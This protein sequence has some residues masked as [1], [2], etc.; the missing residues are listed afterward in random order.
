MA[1]RVLVLF[2][3]SES[4]ET[5][6]WAGLLI[7]R[8]QES[9]TQ[10]DC[11]APGEVECGNGVRRF[12]TAVLGRARRGWGYWLQLSIV[13]PFHSLILH[14]S[15]GYRSVLTFN[16]HLS[17]LT[18]LLMPFRQTSRVLYLQKAPWALLRRARRSLLVRNFLYFRDC[19]GVMASSQVVVP[20]HYVVEKILEEISFLNKRIV[21]QPFSVEDALDN[22]AAREAAVGQE[23]S[24]KHRKERQA[25]LEAYDLPERAL[26]L[27]TADDLIEREPVEILVRAINAAEEERMCLFVL[28]EGPA[29]LQLLAI[30][31]GLGLFHR[32]IFVANP[33]QFEEVIVG[34]DLYVIGSEHHG[35]TR[36]LLQAFASGVPVLAADVP[37]MKEI[38]GEEQLLFS[39]G[40]VE[41]IAQELESVLY[42]RSK[43]R[44]IKQLSDIRAKRYEFD[45][46]AKAASLL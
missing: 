43:Y 35:M 1:D 21:A 34:S 40:S 37:E 5:R 8:L 46:A 45:W 17:L 15:R 41:D 38:V 10:V 7:R 28:G 14:L 39:A 18:F 32:V 25:L 13:V 3:G 44:E 12:N 31:V 20:T 26:L 9:G 24:P 2:S 23:R 16:C 4:A 11:L 33:Q 19:F 6:Y 27:T 42:S 22:A 30:V 29:R 36:P